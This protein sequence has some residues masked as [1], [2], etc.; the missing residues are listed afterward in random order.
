MF[1]L[2]EDYNDGIIKAL[3]TSICM[4]DVICWADPIWSEGYKFMQKQTQASYAQIL[5]PYNNPRCF[6]LERF[7]W[8]L[9]NL[10]GLAIL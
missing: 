3:K 7:K 6:M 4:P 2:F 10:L 8:D 1:V 9:L 5:Y